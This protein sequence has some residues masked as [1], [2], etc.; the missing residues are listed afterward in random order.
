MERVLVVTDAK[1]IAE[2]HARTRP[3]ALDRD[4]AAVAEQEWDDHSLPLGSRVGEFEITDIIGKG[5]FG[6]VYLAWDH[7]LD[8]V[9]ALKEYMPSAFASRQNKTYV[10]PLSERHRDTFQI[11]LNS[12]VNEAKLLAQFHNPSLVEVHRFWEAN[13][14]AYMVMPYYRGKTLGETV[15]A[16]DGP[17]SEDWLLE[18]LAPVTEALMELHSVQC[19]HRD[20]APDN[21]LILTDSGAPMLLDFGAARRVIAGQEHALT[22]I[23]KGGYA[24]IE[25]YGDVPGMQQ[26]GWTDV[27]ALAS[28]VYWAVMGKTPPPAPGRMIRDTYVPLSECAPAQYSPSF[29]AAIDRALVVMPEART[30][31]IAELRKELGLTPLSVVAKTSIRWSDPDATVLH[32][33]TTVARVTE[34]A[35]RPAPVAP[36]P[37]TAPAPVSAPVSAPAP[38][39]AAA[40]EK[41]TQREVVADPAPKRTLPL[42]AIVAGAALI[43]TAAAGAWW[44]S[45]STAPAPAA[46]VAKPAPAQSLPP[47]PVPV[48]KEPDPAPVIETPVPV[49]PQVV[50]PPPVNTV[51]QPPVKAVEQPPVKA[52]EQPPSR[53]EP[54]RK[55]ETQV[56]PAK[57]PAERSTAKSPKAAQDPECEKILMRMSLGEAG[58]DL[59]DRMKTLNCK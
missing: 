41:T 11:G 22:I 6:I 36:A 59:I 13:G 48:P 28:V 35:P 44:F 23:L 29:A 51:K 56:R 7:S 3:G 26:G 27:Y 18:L 20:V 53:A 32:R 38:A 24:P 10:H 33:P 19:Y 43:V 47:V 34:A 9:V 37:V 4:G 52:V 58:Q 42:A 49:Q 8:R 25:Q 15:R 31:S 5:G 55:V 46:E 14:T 50:A 39:P 21:I 54:V 16:L 17:P 57:P 30:Q 12:F 40:R 1:K 45:Q 2:I